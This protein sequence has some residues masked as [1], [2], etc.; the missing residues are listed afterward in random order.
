MI[1]GQPLFTPP[2]VASMDG[3]WNAAEARAVE[4]HLGAAIIG[5]PATVERKLREFR[6]LTE[7]NELM[8]YSDCYRVEDRLHSYEIVAD[9]MEL[10][11]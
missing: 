8:L 6:R 9:K 7:A 3:L 1:R 2:P 11:R 10:G 5:G 4:A